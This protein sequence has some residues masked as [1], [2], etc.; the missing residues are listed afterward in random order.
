MIFASE[1]VRMLF[2]QLPTSR[3]VE[4]TDMEESLAR[5]GQRLH[6][7]SVL[8]HDGCLEVVIRV[9]FNHDTYAFSGN[10]STPT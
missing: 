2:H 3:Q 4:F 5:R 7:D 8:A 9:S 1:D 10:R 6:I